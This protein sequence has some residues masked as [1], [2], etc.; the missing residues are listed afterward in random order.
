MKGT[1][2]RSGSV[3]E[4]PPAGSLVGVAVLMRDMAVTV[5]LCITVLGGRERSPGSDGVAESLMS[6]ILQRARA[7]SVDANVESWP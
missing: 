1:S 6:F 3:A 7:D 5:G 2:G 4:I